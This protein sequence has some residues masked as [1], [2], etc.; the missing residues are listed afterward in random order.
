MEY[1]YAALLLHKAKQPINEEKMKKTLEAAGVAPDLGR[2]K[3]VVAAL[4]GANIDD[5][6]AKAAAVAAAPAAAP[7]AHA[8]PAAEK[9]PE[10]DDKKSEEDAAAGLGALFG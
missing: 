4:N 3:A 2:I 1:L 8:A 5:I 7:T 9:K 10:K 6:I